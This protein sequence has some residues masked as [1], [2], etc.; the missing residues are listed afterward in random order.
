MVKRGDPGFTKKFNL[1]YGDSRWKNANNE[2]DLLNLYMDK[3][4]IHRDIVV[5]IKIK[6]DRGG[7]YYY[8][9]IFATIETKAGSPWMEG[10]YAIKNKIEKNYGQTVERSLKVLSNKNTDLLGLLKEEKEPQKSLDAF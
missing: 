4:R 5:P 7:S 9:L 10:V 6:K 3:I 2:V 1:F 8:H